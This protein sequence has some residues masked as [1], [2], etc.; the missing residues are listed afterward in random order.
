MCFYNVG[1]ITPFK[2]HPWVTLSVVSTN[3]LLPPKENEWEMGMPM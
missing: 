3:E 2:A 1:P